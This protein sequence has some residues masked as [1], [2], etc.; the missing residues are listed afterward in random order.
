MAALITDDF[1][2][3]NADNFVESVKNPDNSYY[4]FVGLP[5]PVGSG[6]GRDLDW[7]NNPLAPVD[8]FSYV[9]HCY[10]TMMYGRRITPANIRRVI[11]RIDWVK[12]SRY[13]QYRDD[14]SVNN[15][16]PNTGAT[17]LYDANYY[18][19]NS[20]FRVYI[21]LSNG[22]SGAN[23]KG[24]G[25]ED[26]PNFVDTEPSEAGSSGDGYVWKYLF[27]VSP[28]DVIKFD[29]TEYITVPNDWLTTDSPQ[30]TA[31][32][33]SG[34]S[35]VNDSQLKQ[36][37][38]DKPGAGYGGGAGQ[39]LAVIGDGEGAR[40]I[41]DVNSGQIV[42]AVI[43]RGGKNYTWGLVDLGSI[44]GSAA[45][46]GAASAAK[47]DVIIPPSRGHGYDIYE[48]LGTDR[49]LLYARFDD[50]TE[51]FPIDTQFAQI[52]L[53]KNP[54]IKDSTA[55][56]TE[57]SFTSADS[58]KLQSTSSGSI[59]VGAIIEQPTSKGLARGYVVSYNKETTVLKYIQDRSLYFNPQTYDNT[60]YVGISTSGEKVPFESNSNTIS[61]VNGSFSSSIDTSFN[62][63]TVIIADRTVELGAEFT[64]GVAESEINKP[65]GEILYLDNRPLVPR[66]PRQK[67]DVKIILEF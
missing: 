61:E 64:N 39:E 6:Y 66:N 48:E 23:P 58:L 56:F 40:A 18:V 2:L 9:R 38:I 4:I 62:G 17:R 65:S 28:A 25:S 1:R 47:L 11:R 50:S 45:I 37:Y 27:T 19:I 16:A 43:A 22:S 20:E 54:T 41:I 35:Q 7:N 31:V 21:C 63:S 29:S 36:I 10:D 34:D 14:Y 30:I 60:D 49:V 24:N 12:G 33:E 32:R 42:N 5:N 3:F 52:G 51:D 26:E 13:E 15:V 57:N 67:E 8:S 53:L 46:G 44:N 55:L 59:E